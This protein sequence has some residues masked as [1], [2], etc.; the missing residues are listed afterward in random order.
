MPFPRLF[1]KKVKET[2][3]KKEERKVEEPLVEVKPQPKAREKKV[4]EAYRILYTPHVTEKATDLVE[5]NQYV[6][7]VQPRA[8]KVEI[9]K[10]IEDLY[11]VEVISVKIIKVPR[12]RR[13]LGRITGWRKG[14]KKAIVRI[15][16][17][18]KIEIMPR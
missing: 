3:I 12:K 15:K 13:R 4:G 14:Y 18:Q 10:A 17:G 8:N 16:E 2:G 6:F 9:K 11:G 5:K 7:K 1:K